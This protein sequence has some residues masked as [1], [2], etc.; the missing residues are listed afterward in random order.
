M[1]VHRDPFDRLIISTAISENMNIISVDD[2]DSYRD[3]L[4]R[5]LVA[6]I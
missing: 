5:K 6:I 1:K 2:P 4:Y 3:K